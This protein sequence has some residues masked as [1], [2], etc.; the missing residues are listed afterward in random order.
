MTAERI[1]PNARA[2]STTARSLTRSIQDCQ[3]ER[4]DCAW[5]L[6][7]SRWAASLPPESGSGD[8]AARGSRKP[9]GLAPAR[10]LVAR[11]RF[12]GVEAA[13][14]RTFVPGLN[15]SHTLQ[16]STA[17]KGMAEAACSRQ[18]A[19]FQDC[20]RKHRRQEVRTTSHISSEP[21]LSSPHWSDSLAW[22]PAC[23]QAL[24]AGRGVVLGQASLSS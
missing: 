1:V 20:L 24:G 17:I 18:L 2:R 22:G 3:I 19:A 15:S 6:S 9:R 21:R 7:D 8:Q 16:L 5:D 13:A 11:L 23:L 10:C 4:L 14:G 12:G